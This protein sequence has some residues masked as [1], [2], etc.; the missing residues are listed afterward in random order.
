MGALVHDQSLA[1]SEWDMTR[2]RSRPAGQQPP[3][4]EER[5]RELRTRLAGLAGLVTT[6][7]VARLRKVLAEVAAGRRLVVQAGDCAEPF[8]ECTPPRVARKVALL[9]RLAAALTATTD[10]PVVRVGRLAGQFA[11]PRS[12]PTETVDGVVLPVY[13]GDLVNDPSPAAAARRAEPARL[14]TGYYAARTAT[15]YLREHAPEVWTSHEALV[16][17]YEIPLLRRDGSGLL[18]GSTHWPWLGDRTRDLDGAHVALLASVVNPV[19]CKVG[20]GIE[21]DQLLALCERLDPHREP[22]RLTLV[23]RLGA[24]RVATRLPALVAAVGSAGHPVIWLCDPMHGNTVTGPDGRKTRVVDTILR[25]TAE[26]QA[27]VRAVGGVSGGLHL[28]TT[29]D[30]VGECVWED[31]PTGRF[32]SLCDPRLNPGQALAVVRSWAAATTIREE[33][34][35]A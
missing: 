1:L 33:K 20:P 15:E 30:P 7:E 29:P 25:E 27:A 11:K 12:R 34:S 6:D 8:A 2:L 3:W 23:A 14:L 32:T 35:I 28:E 10:L 24:D 31:A 18:L 19:A 26:F 22:G 21:V 13:R 5:A 16:L 9:Y 17:D 4:P